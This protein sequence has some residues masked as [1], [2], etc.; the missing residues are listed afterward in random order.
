MTINFY[1]KDRSV[2][3]TKLIIQ[4]WVNNKRA[5]LKNPLWINTDNWD[6]K[7]QKIKQGKKE[8]KIINKTL[9]EYSE[10]IEFIF[11]KLTISGNVSA[12]AIK[13][14]F[15]KKEE[16]QTLI[17]FCEKL[18][19][20]REKKGDFA[21]GT[22]KNY[23]KH[24]GV[25]KRFC[26]DMKKEY[27]FNDIDFAFI[28]NFMSWLADYPNYYSPNY[29]NKVIVDLRGFLS[30]AAEKGHI[31]E[32]HF[33]SKKFRFKTETPENVFSTENELIKVHK[34]DVPIHLKLSKDLFIIAAFTGQRF[35]DFSKIKKKY[36]SEIDGVKVL[37]RITQKTK[38]E[39]I[40]PLHP[41]VLQILNDYNFELPN[42][43]TNKTM[44]E[45]I[46]EIYKLAGID[47][48]TALLKRVKGKKVLVTKP[49]HDWVTTHTARR[50]A[51]TNMLIAGV[52]EWQVVKICGW[53]NE[54]M[55][56]EIYNKMKKEEIAVMAAQNDF[57][58]TKIISV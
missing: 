34:T 16:K 41:V 49:K 28:D 14:E 47:E 11:D 22:I 5:R 46:K 33:E 3:R 38:E 8:S 12:Q 19:I 27:D 56:R 23:R 30:E 10:E 54:K 39:I 21:E 32:K 58:K 15:E 43:K 36:I 2:K 48:P 45:Q 57:F 53:K 25:F 35:G 1:L 9:L 13:A 51:S 18:I 52:P 29:S 24:L 7:K 50:S 6:F 55:L 44:N 17:Q 4:I 31:K 37:R 42:S 20:S 26:K 40:V